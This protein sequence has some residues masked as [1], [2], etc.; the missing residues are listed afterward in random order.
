[1]WDG[2]L[3]SRVM[4]RKSNEILIFASMIRANPGKKDAYID[5]IN[6]LSA[7]IDAGQAIIDATGEISIESGSIVSK[8]YLDR[9]SPAER[10]DENVFN[11]YKTAPVADDDE[12]DSQMVGYVR[13]LLKEAV[14]SMGSGSPDDGTSE[15]ISML[16]TEL[17]MCRERIEEL[18]N[19]LEYA[20]SELRSS[21]ETNEELRAEVEELERR[22]EDAG[23]TDACL[24]TETPAAPE[25]EVEPVTE[26]APESVQESP[27]ASECESCASEASEEVPDAASEPV[28]ERI[29]VD[30]VL[31]DEQ[32]EIA[33]TVRAMKLDKID[34][35]IDM[36]MSG[37]FNVDACDDVV[38]FLKVDVEICD[39]LLSMDYYDRDSIE[40]GFQRILDVHETA[41]EPKHQKM[42]INSLNLA[43]KRIESQYVNLVA[44]VQD[45]MLRRFGASE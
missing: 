36:S 15:A 30:R 41:P 17:G 6:G 44:F 4:D 37:S 11:S 19:Q 43:E 34:H 10:Q 18:S 32:L 38:T 7:D 42:Y 9:L 12:K 40:A 2:E 29:V 22:L 24:C 5:I 39:A 8:D 45:A 16:K 26:G 20:R 13:D 1:M 23:K 35:F 14:Q 31:T 3:I 33:R 28:E 27:E 25:P 21:T